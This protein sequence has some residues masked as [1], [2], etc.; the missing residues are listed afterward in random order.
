MYVMVLRHRLIVLIVLLYDLLYCIQSVWDNYI[1]YCNSICV[2][3]LLFV[4]V[5]K[6]FFPISF[7]QWYNSVYMCMLLID[8]ITSVSYVVGNGYIEYYELYI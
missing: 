4:A 7:P 5:L 8:S 6:L 1:D 3:S 2:I